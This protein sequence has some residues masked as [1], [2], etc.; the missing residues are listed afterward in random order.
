MKIAIGSDHAGFHLKQY[1][2]HTLR[3]RGHDITDCGSYDEGSVDY[4][5][6]AKAVSELVVSGEVEKGIVICG[7]G[8]GISI[9]ANKIKGIRAALCHTEYSALMARQ[10]N[11]ANVLALGGEVLGKSLA[12][13]IADVF[14]G[15]LFSG[16]SRHR[17]RIDK[18][19]GLES[20]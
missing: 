10:H 11:D 14:L 15:E 12:L 2:L 7:T 19:S 1:L 3:E 13:A 6:Y 16:G 8:I 5:D 18:I 17:Q 4:P 20:E 9:A